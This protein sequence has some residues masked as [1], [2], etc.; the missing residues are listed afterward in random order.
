[1]ANYV[2]NSSLASALSSYVTSAY[3]ISQNY[4]KIA[5]IAN[6]LQEIKSTSTIKSK[7]NCSSASEIILTV[8][9]VQKGKFYVPT[10]TSTCGF[11]A[12]DKINWQ[13]Q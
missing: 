1:M 13:S 9:D 6:Y 7:V 3:L 12:D 10:S 5:D 2:T 4:L 8:N 11:L